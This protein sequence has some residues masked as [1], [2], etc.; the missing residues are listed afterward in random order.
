MA[1][2]SEFTIDTQNYVRNR[3]SGNINFLLF[4]IIF[5][6]LDYSTTDSFVPSSKENTNTKKFDNLEILEKKEND[7]DLYNNIN[8]KN[9][10]DKKPPGVN[11]QYKHIF[12]FKN[13]NT[14]SSINNVFGDISEIMIPHSFL[15]HLMINNK[16]ISTSK[17]Y[18]AKVITTVYYSRNNNQL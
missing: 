12:Y 1:S 17:R 14:F 6:N 15:D 2:I 8:I 9:Q 7:N 4:F 5:L 11:K 16:N 3:A 18:K 13:K 10:L